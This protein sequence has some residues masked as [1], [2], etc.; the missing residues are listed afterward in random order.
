M[1]TWTAELFRPFFSMHAL[2]GE[3]VCPLSTFPAGQHLT[4]H[5]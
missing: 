3:Q 4:I 2:L 5:R 1:L